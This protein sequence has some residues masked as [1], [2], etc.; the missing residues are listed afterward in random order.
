MGQETQKPILLGVYKNVPWRSLTSIDEMKSNVLN[1]ALNKFNQNLIH[2][3]LPTISM[4]TFIDPKFWP[5]AKNFIDQI[6][7]MDLYRIRAK[8]SNHKIVT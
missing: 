7:P 8:Y 6:S 1:Q 2:K 3:R 4:K 5:G